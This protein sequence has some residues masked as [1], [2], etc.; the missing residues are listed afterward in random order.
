MAAIF[1]VPKGSAF[2]MILPLFFMISS[3][4]SKSQAPPKAKAVYSPK[5]KPQVYSGSMPSFL[6]AFAIT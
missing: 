3:A 2:C 4:E 5:D 1:V 6:S